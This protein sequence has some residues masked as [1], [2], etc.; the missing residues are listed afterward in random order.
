MLE[1]RTR[2]HDAGR[3][4]SLLA[5]L[6]AHLGLR[7]RPEEGDGHDAHDGDEGDEQGVLHEGGPALVVAEAGAQ[8]GG[9][10]FVVG[11]HGVT[12][13]VTDVANAFA[14]DD[15]PRGREN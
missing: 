11:E 5:A 6:G 15:Y 13:K 12:S 9:Q 8:V 7:R 2:G 1:Q 4:P 10:E 14:T 3:W